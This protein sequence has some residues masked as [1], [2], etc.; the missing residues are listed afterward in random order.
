MPVKKNQRVGPTCNKCKE[1]KVLCSLS[2]EAKRGRRVEEPVAG[3][4]SGWLYE[5]FERLERRF[6]QMERLLENNTDAL[7]A[8]TLGLSIYR[9]SDEVEDEDEE[10]PKKSEKAK[11]KR[12]QK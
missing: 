7:E 6:E 2:K 4:S 9:C 8:V 11:G 3:P 10:E 5:M 1:A 12:K